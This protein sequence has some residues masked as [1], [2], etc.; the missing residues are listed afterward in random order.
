MIEWMNEW[1]DEQVN[2]CTSDWMNKWMNEWANEWKNEWMMNERVYEL[3]NG[4]VNKWTSEWMNENECGKAWEVIGMK[5]NIRISHFAHFKC[6]R[7][8]PTDWP[9]N[10]PTDLTL[11]RNARTHLKS[12]TVI[13]F[14]WESP[15]T[16]FHDPY[17]CTS[18]VIPLFTTLTT[19]TTTTMM[20]TN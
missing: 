4:R 8:W 3:M 13:A 10:Q 7:D 6:L 11:H 19:T 2:E 9:T 12:P 1:I 14:V 18:R 15:L 17:S 5:K 20:M 16:K